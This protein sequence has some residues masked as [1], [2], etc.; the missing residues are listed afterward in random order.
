MVTPARGEIWWVNLDPTS[1]REQ[2]GKRP[3]LVVSANT[4]NAGPRELVWILPMTRTQRPY[5]FRVMVR[6]QESGLP[7]LSYIM[8]EQIR[9]IAKERFLDSAPAGRVSAETMRTVEGL[10]QILLDFPT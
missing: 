4:F 1:G 6:S 3:A 8:C 9:C 5:P 10:L 7:T 2:S